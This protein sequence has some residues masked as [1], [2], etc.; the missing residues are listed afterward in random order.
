MERDMLEENNKEPASQNAEVGSLGRYQII[1]PIAAGGMGEVFL[2]KAIGAAGFEKKVVIKR[3]RPH[4]AQDP[5]FV[6]RFI[7]EGRVVVQLSH[8]NVAQVFDMGEVDGSYFIA[9][10]YVE[11][12]D[13]RELNR[14]A[15][16]CGRM[17]PVG[18]VLFVLS[19]IADGLAHAHACK[20]DEGA[21]VGIIHRDV[22][23][24]N[25]ML[26]KD[27]AVKLVDFGVAKTQVFHQESLGGSIRGKLQYMSPEQANA[28][29]LTS[30]S[31]VFSLGVVAY[32]LLSG[33][34]PFDA[35]TDVAVI[36]RVRFED[37]TPLKDCVD[38]MPEALMD[39]VHRALSKEA[40]QRP[41]AAEFCREALSL[42]YETGDTR[43]DFRSFM[44]EMLSAEL[45]ENLSLDDA[46]M[47][48]L[49]DPV[50]SL[51]TGSQPGAGTATIAP[52]FPTLVAGDEISLSRMLTPSSFGG[53]TNVLVST[54]L[55][56]STRT[57]KTL[58]GILALLVVALIG[59]NLMLLDENKT[60][61]EAPRSPSAPALGPPTSSGNPAEKILG[62][63]APARLEVQEEILVSRRM[64]ESA[65]E[66]PQETNV[67]TKG[68][69]LDTR[70]SGGRVFWGGKDRGDA[71]V[72]FTLETGEKIEGVVKLSG[73]RSRKFE[74]SFEDD[75][76]VWIKLRSLAKGAVRFRFRPADAT[77]LLNGRAMKGLTNNV[78]QRDLPVGSHTITVVAPDTGKKRTRTFQIE[79]DQ[80]EKL[81]TVEP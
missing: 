25:I 13:L 2:A 46:L 68:F 75:S 65:A 58:V 34:R 27:G 78:V 4:L 29:E 20:D 31:D 39:L 71:P 61:L 43:E 67:A 18:Q 79:A 64:S 53:D 14:R 35:D 45:D 80:I 44:Q 11:G 36:D 73:H 26:S 57:L 38:N 8:P 22:S 23:P 33:K 48:A 37:P 21:P 66:K 52:T 81:G 7:G 17:V 30:R 51:N 76:S 74:V 42:L 28:S 59:V 62:S 32:E 24:S 19:S 9:M 15:K 63:V 5:S 10:E 47:R 3:I 1:A 77:V 72:K 55:G 50:P 54:P 69:V 6:R 12:C 60:E 49:N 70:P 40:S 56:S 41:D 16:A